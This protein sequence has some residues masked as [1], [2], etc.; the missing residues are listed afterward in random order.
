[1]SL[2]IRVAAGTSM[3]AVLAL[4]GC[5]SGETQTVTDTPVASATTVTSE[6]VSAQ[7][8]ATVLQ[9][10]D[11]V[12][13]DVRSPEEFAQGH[14]DRAV[15]ID[16]NGPDFAGEVAQLDPSTT[17]AV[18]CKSGNRSAAAVSVM[19]D[20]GFTSLYDLGGGIGSWQSAGYPV[21]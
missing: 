11:V 6:V 4:G 20:Q 2:M 21:V 7:E 19:T 3:A 10:L 16:I 8:F 5:A 1:M 9:E 17:Y 12:I 14:I 18:Y 13:L 15:N